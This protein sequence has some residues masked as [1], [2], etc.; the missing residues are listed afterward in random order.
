MRERARARVWGY[1]KHAWKL[2]AGVWVGVCL[3]PASRA[4]C[5]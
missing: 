3:H 2:Q 5:S 4:S 1:G